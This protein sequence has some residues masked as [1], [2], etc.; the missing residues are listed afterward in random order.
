VCKRFARKTTVFVRQSRCVGEIA[1]LANSLPRFIDRRYEGPR[2]SM[3]RGPRGRVVRVTIEG[4]TSWHLTETTASVSSL[5][6]NLPLIFT[7]K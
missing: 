6:N 5:R 7:V 4:Q 3:V 1:C 2:C